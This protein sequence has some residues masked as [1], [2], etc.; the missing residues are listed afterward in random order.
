MASAA[1]HRAAALAHQSIYI[2]SYGQIADRCSGRTNQ[3]AR[4]APLVNNINA[5]HAALNW[6]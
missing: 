3:S 6:P 4:F 5:D 1:R 2:S